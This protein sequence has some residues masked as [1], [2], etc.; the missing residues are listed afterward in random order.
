M[1][2][3][4]PE[5]IAGSK[6]SSKS[7]LLTGG[8]FVALLVASPVLVIV[9]SPFLDSG[10]IWKHLR[11][12]VLGRYVTNSMI[13]ALGTGFGTALLGLPLAW[14]VTMYAFPG[15]RLIEWLLLLPLAVPTYLMAY[16]FTDF[17]DYA[18]PIQS[19]LRDWTGWGPR[20]YW[21][22]DI[23]SLGGAI[24]IFSFVFYPYVYLYCRASF[25]EQSVSMLDA[26]RTLGM[27][28]T[29]T[30]RRVALPL[31]R[32]AL[33][34]GIA[35][36]I[37]ETLADFGAVDYF[38]VDTFT[39]GIYRTWFGLGS[40]VG[41]AQLS[42]ALLGIVVFFILLE[43]ITRGK[44]KFHPVTTRHAMLPRWSMGTRNGYLATAFCLL[45]ITVGFLLPTAI[46]IYHATKADIGPT[47]AESLQW[48]W[49][50]FSLATITA[51]IAVVFSLVLVYNC[52][53]S[54]GLI[55]K[56]LAR[57]ASTGYAIPGSVIAIGIL[58]LLGWAD[59]GLGWLFGDGLWISGTIVGLIFAYLSRFLTVCLQS[60]ESG[61]TK[62]APSMDQAGRTLRSGPAAI[63]ARIHFPLLRSS[64]L[65]GALLVFV[66]VLKE[67]PATL[68]IRPFNYDTLAIKVYHLASDERLSEAAIPALLI[69]AV[70]LIPVI[71]LSRMMTDPRSPKTD[72]SETFS[73]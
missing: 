25:L 35:L 33:A 11:E 47:F 19:L 30:F 49:H 37:M 21:F 69:L 54:Q 5:K 28:R 59:Q 64:I 38:A 13:L 46:L 73:E 71:I 15:R 26:S 24:F 18:G 70:G 51:I 43:R 61:M 6:I 3:S 41:A 67:L 23:R 1:S 40:P 31:A 72:D 48:A 7:I 16:A 42:A 29:S 4:H 45:P 58:L 32:P 52:R 65:A 9:F 10:D 68:I 17:L 55:P 22:P 62:I 57:I 44:R 14:L 34:G 2:N 60:V 36:A 20:D 39:T 50:S 56:A 53:I 66:E 12:T 63:L 27:S 8:F